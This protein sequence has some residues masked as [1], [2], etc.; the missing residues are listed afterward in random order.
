MHHSPPRAAARLWRANPPVSVR[1]TCRPQLCAQANPDPMI[2]VRSDRPGSLAG[3]VDA[4]GELAGRPV[5]SEEHDCPIAIA[6]S[7]GFPAG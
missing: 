7:K 1:K 4:H 2:K 6:T 3:R 5:E